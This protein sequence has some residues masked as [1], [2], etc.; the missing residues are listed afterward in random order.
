MPSPN[1]IKTFTEDAY[2]HVYNRG[3]EK[4]RIFEDAEDYKK[5]LYYLKI[6]LTPTDILHQQQPLMRTY[7]VKNNL[8]DEVNLLSFCLMPNHFHLLIHQKNKDGI[9][10]LM[11][12]LATAYSMYFNKRYER[13]GTLFQ[14]VYKAVMVT[15]DEQ[16]LHLSR[17]IHLNPIARGVSIQDFQW[18]SY[19]SYVNQDGPVWVNTSPIL[20]FFNNQ[21]PN[22]SYQNFVEKSIE[23]TTN[24]GQLTLD[25]SD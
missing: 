9:S 20:D 2:Y 16:L 14:G 5:F 24:I 12:Q 11:K 19:K 8:A 25:Q 21:N 3:V 4:R 15:S 23:T 1:T 10:K 17:Y 18:S 13:I 22:F 6:Y 7:I